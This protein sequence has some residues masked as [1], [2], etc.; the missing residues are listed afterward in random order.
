MRLS[1][2]FASCRVRPLSESVNDLFREVS[3][4]HRR[5]NELTH[6]LAALEPFLRRHGYRGEGVAEGEARGGAS[7]APLAPR[8]TRGQVAA[9]RFSKHPPRNMLK[10][11]PPKGTRVVRRKRVRVFRDGSTRVVQSER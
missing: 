10:L 3:L 2:P 11:T 1:L 7:T 4:M 5:I 6:R 9:A 8:N